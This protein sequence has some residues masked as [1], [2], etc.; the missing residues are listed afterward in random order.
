[1][2]CSNC[3]N[4]LKEEAMF[5]AECGAKVG[6]QTPETERQNCP[7][8]GNKVN[9]GAMFCNECGKNI[10]QAPSN[11]T[12][13]NTGNNTNRNV[14]I[15][16]IIGLVVVL[17]CAV[18]TVYLYFPNF[19]GNNNTITETHKK[20]SSKK[21]K[22]DMDYYDDSQDNDYDTEDNYY[23]SED[24]EIY[25]FPSDREY[26]TEADLYG[27]SKEE[28]ALIRNE[29]YAR[30]GYIFNTEPFKS[31]F[32]AKD[33]YTPNPTFDDGDFNVIEKANKDF[34]VNYE[35]KKGWR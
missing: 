12:T 4:E 18:A 2:K 16:L 26:I 21:N 6:A 30:H 9:P 27:K 13:K 25:L 5:C 28:V 3:G 24:E 7:H 15:A 10:Y 8:C 22:K 19:I 32:A 20:K 14:V 33:W 11:G 23:D 31:Y 34:I 17:L 35:K 1:M 29:I